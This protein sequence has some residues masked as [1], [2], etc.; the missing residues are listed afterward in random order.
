MPATNTALN[1]YIYSFSTRKNTYVYLPYKQTLAKFERQEWE[2]IKNFNVSEEMRKQLEAHKIYV[3]SNYKEE[4]LMYYRKNFIEEVTP[5]PRIMY[6]IAT[7]ACNFNCKYCFIENNFK[8][9]SRSAQNA[10]YIKKWIDR[11]NALANPGTGLKFIFYGGEPLLNADFVIEAINYI[12]KKDSESN[13]HSII[14]INTNGS[15]YSKELSECFKANDVILSVSLDGPK[16]LND[17]CRVT[18]TGLPT[19]ET[20]YENINK[21]INDGVFVGL[22]ITITKFNLL[23]L[24]QIAKW[25]VETFN[26]KIR[27]VGFNPPLE[28]EAGNPATVDDF[29]LT[30]L[31]IYNA[32]R[33]FRKHGIYEDRIMRRLK[34]IVEEKPYLKDCA[35]CGNQI[36]VAADGKI[37]PCQA[38]IGIGDYFKHVDPASYSFKSDPV[39]N[40]W[41]KI[42]PINKGACEDCPFILLCGN[43]CP[44]YAKLK[45]GSLL[46][47]DKRY[48][49]MMPIMINEVLKDNFYGKVKALFLDYDGVIVYR[50]PLEEILAKIAEMLS[51]HYSVSPE[52]IIKEKKYFDVR[53][54]FIR[55]GLHPDT[56]KKALE[57]YASLFKEGTKPALDLIR[58]LDLI[59]L[60]KY[61]LTNNDSRYVREEL[62][63]FGISNKFNGIYGG[64]KIKKN[65]I[66][67]YEKVLAETRLEPEEVL[68]V[69]DS[70]MDIA[71]PYVEGMRVALYNALEGPA[72]M[73][74]NWLVDLCQ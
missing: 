29:K 68:Y 67:F 21:Y 32:F 48:C 53:E 36:V 17:M 50:K 64:E 6:I 70:A 52:E 19:F 61:I 40:E 10:E 16:E 31:Q 66:E 30:M 43:G 23:Y 26:N 58:Q 4:M 38:F 54:F 24:P 62:E 51:V 35:G 46:G 69:G 8:S 5:S 47:I 41:H 2:K 59:P 14:S 13:R 9:E 37:G 73:A 7:D 15:I 57:Y 3:G 25:V 45:T 49:D 20:V 22:S 71:L 74:N 44:Y 27:S 28:S 42:S 60:K 1:P 63:H 11:I 56:L 34:Y 55:N 39:M 65:T 18:K 12:R 72:E 33:I